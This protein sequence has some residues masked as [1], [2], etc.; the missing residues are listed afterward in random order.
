[1]GSEKERVHLLTFEGVSGVCLTQYFCTIL[2]GVFQGLVN[3]YNRGSVL[4]GLWVR[5]FITYLIFIGGMNA[6]ME[7]DK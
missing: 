4:V 3:S 6:Y 7:T 1:M 2:R 5:L